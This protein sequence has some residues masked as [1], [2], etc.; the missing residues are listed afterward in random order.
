MRENTSGLNVRPDDA[1]DT[2][3]FEVITSRTDAT[4]AQVQP[5]GEMNL[6]NVHL[7]TCVLSGQLALGRRFVRLDLSRLT[8]SDSAC[9][10]FLVPAHERF[11][12]DHGVLALTNVGGQL[13]QL[14]HATQLDRTLLITAG[15]GSDPTEQEERS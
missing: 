7:L 1:T 11:L 4:H 2:R 13:A 6:T 5:R 10:G 12:A 3:T 14:L 15:P 9:L 8:V